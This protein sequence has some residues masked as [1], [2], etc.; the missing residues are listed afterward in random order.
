MLLM[1][2]GFQG[3]CDSTIKVMDLFSARKMQ[4]VEEEKCEGEKKK[5]HFI[6]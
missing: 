4:E 2:Y 5:P 3:H 1:A 6:S